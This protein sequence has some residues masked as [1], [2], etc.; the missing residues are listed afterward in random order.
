MRSMDRYCGSPEIQEELR[1]KIRG[2]V[3]TIKPT[4]G[5]VY[6]EIVNNLSS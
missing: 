5:H 1:N 6:D 2:M 4:S 3:Q